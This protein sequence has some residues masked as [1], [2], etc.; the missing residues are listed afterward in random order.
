MKQL[1]LLL[2][3]ACAVDPADDELVQSV[4]EVPIDELVEKYCPGVVYADGVTTYRGLTGTYRRYGAAPA[5]EPT[6]LTLFAFRD[7]P[8]AA[9]TFTGTRAPNAPFAGKFA[10]I[11]DNPAIGAAISFDVGADGV[12]D[13]THFVLGTRR[14]YG[15][16]A[17]LCLA[18]A[19]TPFLM[20][21]TFF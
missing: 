8:D 2:L 12:W 10:A 3:A 7:D 14:S 15:R 1:A 13:Q 11:G 21:R 4:D 17:A 18:G 9:G 5:G 16:V 6:K 20:T 19:E